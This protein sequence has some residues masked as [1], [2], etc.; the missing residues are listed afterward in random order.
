MNLHGILSFWGKADIAIFLIR[1][2]QTVFWI[3]NEYGRGMVFTK[4]CKGMGAG[5][6]F[7]E[8]CHAFPS[9]FPTVLKKP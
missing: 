4:H 7:R 2:G 8:S 6:D 5:H 1:D 9:T 3:E